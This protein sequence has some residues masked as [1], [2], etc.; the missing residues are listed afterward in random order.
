MKSILFLLGFVAGLF[1]VCQGACNLEC[2]TQTVTRFVDDKCY[3]E[4]EDMRHLVNGDCYDLM[5]NGLQGYLPI[6][7]HTLS[8]TEPNDLQ[9]CDITVEVLDNM[10]PYIQAIRGNPNLFTKEK[11]DNKWRD[12]LFH[13]NK[14]ENC[15][16]LHCTITDVTYEDVDAECCR[17]GHDDDDHDDDDDRRRSGNGNGNGN[18]DDDD[19][20]NR[21]CLNDAVQ[22]YITGPRTVRLCIA[23]QGCKKRTYTVTGTC[24]DESGNSS[25]QTTT[26][27][28]VKKECTRPDPT[29]EHGIQ[30]ING[31]CCPDYCGACGGLGCGARPGGADKCCG[32]QV[33]AQ[34]R[35]C[36]EYPAP[37][38]QTLR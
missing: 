18:D 1:G 23:N 21:T 25:Q 7:E 3:Y 5:Q 20:N 13:F 16:K 9:S 24:V 17:N 15:C 32:N 30:G 29:C 2:P 38:V 8:V 14:R 10:P 27:V 34:G 28:A 26:V 22:Y 36:D 19:E 6:G 37:C 31:A 12:V 4:V 11:C 33:L 35:S